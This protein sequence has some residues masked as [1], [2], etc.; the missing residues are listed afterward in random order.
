MGP[1]AISDVWPKVFFGWT[2]QP[3]GQFSIK[4]IPDYTLFQIFRLLYTFSDVNINE[5]WGINGDM[6]NLTIGC[7]SI[8]SPVFPLI[9]T[10]AQ[11]PKRCISKFY[12]INFLS[13]CLTKLIVQFYQDLIFFRFCE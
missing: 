8:P 6:V 3:N 10:K 4:Q 2:F 12:H 7:F 9:V 1:L 11:V 5:G 13:D